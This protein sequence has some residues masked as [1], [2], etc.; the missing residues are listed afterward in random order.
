M[1]VIMVVCVCVCVC[2]CV[3]VFKRPQIGSDGFNIK[4]NVPQMRDSNQD[5]ECCCY[6][7]VQYP[8]PHAPLSVQLSV[9]TAI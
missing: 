2:V 6:E 9:N 4:G 1:D 5:K 3:P 7:E 8:E